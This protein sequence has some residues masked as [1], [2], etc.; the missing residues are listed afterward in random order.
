MGEHSADAV[1]QRVEAFFESNFARLQYAD[2]ERFNLTYFRHTGQWWEIAQLLSLEECLS[3]VE[4][5]CLFTR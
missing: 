2:D 4:A 1:G 5:G 3:Q